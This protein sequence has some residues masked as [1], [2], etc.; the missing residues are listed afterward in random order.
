MIKEFY[1]S[2]FNLARHLFILNFNVKLFYLTHSWT[3]SVA[4]TLSQNG[5]GGDGNEEV[6][7]IPQSASITVTSQ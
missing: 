5:H 7:A 2:Q 6:P 3:L 1:F 4:T